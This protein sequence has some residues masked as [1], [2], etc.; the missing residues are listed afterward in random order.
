MTPGYQALRQGAAWLD[1]SARGHLVVRGEDRM[2]FLHAMSSNHI[3]QLKPGTGCYAFFLD[4]QGRI[5]AD[6][7]I[8]CRED[9]FL[10]DTEPEPFELLLAHLDRHIIAD[11]VTLEDATEAT[12]AIAIEGPHAADVLASL[13][14]P[15][16]PAPHHSVVWGDRVTASLSATGA[17]G[18]RVFLPVSATGEFTSQ[19]EASGAVRAEPGDVRAVRLEYGRPRY[20]EDITEL[21]LPQETQLLHA[22]HFNKGCYIGQEIVERIRS[23]GLVNRLLIHMKINAAEAPSPGCT[24]TIGDE[25]VGRLTS[26]AVSPELGC[27]VAMGYVR[28]SHARAGTRLLAG[29]A[30]AE[31][32]GLAPV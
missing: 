3:E 25:K 9:L 4:A 23:R 30:E 15:T 20:G 18:F 22:L 21:S 17:N 16:P 14:A 27:V 5:Q 32:T 11:D 24:L 7:H 12:A 1:L 10:V 19:L 29:D 28:A 2:R 31:L 6:A 26:A 8:L 13:G